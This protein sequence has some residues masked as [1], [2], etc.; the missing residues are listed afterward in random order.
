MALES[1]LDP[2][3]DEA[4]LVLQLDKSFLRALSTVTGYKQCSEVGQGRGEYDSLAL[5]NQ[6]FVHLTQSN[7]RNHYRLLLTNARLQR[8]LL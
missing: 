5:P 6:L 1:S 7:I 3:H 8:Y 2:L 4:L